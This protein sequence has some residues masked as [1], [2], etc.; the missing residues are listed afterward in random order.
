VRVTVRKHKQLLLFVEPHKSASASIQNSFVEHGT[1]YT[2]ELRQEAFQKWA[3]PG[4]P[5]AKHPSAFG[6]LVTNW[7]RKGQSYRD[8]RRAEFYFTAHFVL[9]YPPNVILGQE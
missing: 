1:N 7:V 5:F 6:E 4:S 8:E 2:G 3:W 9:Q